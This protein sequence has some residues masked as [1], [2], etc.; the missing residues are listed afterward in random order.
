M[1]VGVKQLADPGSQARYAPS[2]I[3][4]LTAWID[5]LPIPAW[6]FYLVGVIGLALLISASLWIDGSVAFGSYGYYQGIFPPFVFYFLALYHY[7]TGAGSRSLE[8]FRP[9]L[10]ENEAEYARI[11]YEFATLPRWLGWLAIA[12]A[13]V[14]L[15]PYFLE[16]QA[17]GNLEPNTF[18]P[19]PIAAVSAVFFGATI[20]NLIFR[21]LRQLRMVHR[22]HAQASN[23]DLLRLEP[24]H[25]FAGFTA[26]TGVGIILLLVLGYLYNPESFYGG[27][28]LASYF[29]MAVPSVVVFVVP[30]MGMR[31]RLQQE[32]RQIL[33]GIGELLQ[34]TSEKLED[35][36][37]AADYSQ[38]QGMETAIRALMAKRDMIARISTWPWNPATIRGFVSTLLLPI[39]LWLITRLLERII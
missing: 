4:H 2:W 13:I 9:L 18:L 8:Q 35:K 12:I 14:T 3:D 34:L 39:V 27:Y 20:F 29:I 11:E 6:V 33:D 15:P 1:A 37:R 16:G 36:V 10:Q 26:R 31:S 30:V 7:L 25:A 19:Y 38:L 22:L 28:L 21:S 32:K 5:R 23:I 17:F 24:A